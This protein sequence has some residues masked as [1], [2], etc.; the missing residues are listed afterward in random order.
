MTPCL[1]TTIKQNGEAQKKRT[2]YLV[3]KVDSNYLNKFQG[4]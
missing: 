3:P 2:G 1:L 4:F